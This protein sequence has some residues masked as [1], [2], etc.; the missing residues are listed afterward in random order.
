MREHPE[1]HGLIRLVQ[2]G[3]PSREDV[4]AYQ[5]LRS[6]AYELVGRI[7]GRF[8]T[9]HWVP[10]YW[11]HRAL[12]REAVVA[13]YRAADVMLVTPIRDGMNLVA[14]E[15]V[16]SRTDG[17]GVLVLSEFAG[18][19]AE[20]A[21]ALHVNPFDVAGA[22]NAYCTRLS[23]CTKGS[24]A[25]ACGRCSAASLATTWSAGRGASWRPSIARSPW[26]SP[27]RAQAPPTEERRALVARMQ[28]ARYL[29]LFL[30]FDGTLV[31][32]APLPEL[33][34]PDA[35]LLE[36]LAALSARPRTEVH[37]V[38]GR[39]R[40][41][42]ERWLGGLRIGL[43][44]EHGFWSRRAGAQEW[45]C[46]EEPNLEWRSAV[47]SILE[48]WSARTPGSLVEEKSICIAW[49]YR[50]AD[51]EFGAHPAKELHIHL[52]E[53]LSNVPVEILAGDKVIEVRPHAANKGRM[54][55]PI[56]AA[57]PRKP[58]RW[59]SVTTIRTR[60]SSPPCPRTPSRSTSDPGKAGRAGTS[61]AS[62]KR[63]RCS[64]HC[65]ARCLR[66]ALR[67]LD[68][69]RLGAKAHDAFVCAGAQGPDV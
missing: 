30:D 13:L 1:L 66:A 19:A 33:A 60:T 56:L 57:R 46:V 18:A 69:S 39:S 62:P 59:R 65:F 63:V 47:L 68:F 4:D 27:D 52:R 44:A 20:L 2:I 61:R 11:I 43:H 55:L 48:D 9:P 41:S 28:R 8:A 26:S 17:D 67:G 12:T 5:T 31:P 3:V 40:E 45:I 37:V 21:E 53:L 42:L 16:A 6:Q 54:V 10:I 51:P 29:L 50:A 25:S 38:S 15:F 35:E 58:R 23:A 49:H 34:K 22:A 14:K 36:L 7:H 64:P 32:F 24:V